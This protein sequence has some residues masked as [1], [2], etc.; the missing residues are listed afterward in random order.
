[1][2]AVE[3]DGVSLFYSE[4]GS[5]PPVVFVHGIPTDYRAWEAQRTTL[6]GEFRTVR[7]SRR[8][9]YPNP[10][11]GDLA[12]STVENNALDL[13][14]LIAK[15][16]LAPVHLVGHSYGGFIAAYLAL[17][18]P[19]L[20]RSLTLVEPAIASLLLRDPKSRAQAFGLLL[21]HPRVAFSASKFLR[22]SNAPALEALRR[23]DTAAA[24]RFNLDGVENRKGVLEQL[25]EPIRK[26][27]LDN[28]RTV[29]ET[30]TPFP[31]VSRGELRTLRV[32]TLLVHGVTSALWLRAITEMAAAAI[33]GAT[34]VTVPNSG[35]Y[36]HFQNPAPFNTALLAFLRRVSA[37]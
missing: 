1:M 7:Y 8:Y 5:G 18:Q 9:A 22:E 20:L 24:V 23:N 17:R 37:G 4:E 10:R 12:D 34:T 28:G 25:P 3:V 21:R 30:D 26:M 15:L 33:P 35:H 6:S 19:T 11:I 29:K 2:T 14:G 31:V 13:A 27:M 16:G 32:P 36:P